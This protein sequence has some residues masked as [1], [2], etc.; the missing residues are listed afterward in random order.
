M[1]QYIKKEERRKILRT[2]ISLA[3]APLLGG[4]VSCSREQQSVEAQQEEETLEVAQVTQPPTLLP[5]EALSERVILIN[6][7]PGN[8]LALETD[9]GV[10]LVDSG[11]AAMAPSVQM[12][13]QESLA[14]SQVHTLINTHYHAD[15]SGGNPLFGEAGAA[16]HSHEITRQWL[17]SD[18][19]IPAEER[20]VSALP[21]I[22]RPTHT[23]RGK[24]EMTAG[25]ESIEFGYLLE[26]HTRGDAYVYL[27]DSNILAVGD[28]ASPLRDPSLDWYAGGWLG[29][30]VDAMDDLLE[31][32]NA[33]TLIVPAYGPVMTLAEYQAERDMMWHLWERC[34]T[35]VNN[36]RSA[37]DVLDAGV[38]DEIDRTF[39]DPYQFLY[40]VAKGLWAHYTNFGGNVV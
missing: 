29:G 28:V 10:V 15:Q 19:Y 35:L 30:R 6:N 38:M 8:V 3:S 4:L 40:D 13:L 1:T 5:T 9:N 22:G 2:G 26:A 11:S 31:V 33:D 18:H 12:T 24:E 14:N 7:A 37:Q 21:V 36:G 39:D 25:A 17:S 32:A 23:F 16:I 34:S 20:W 27:R